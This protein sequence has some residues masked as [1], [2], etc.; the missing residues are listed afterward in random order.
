MPVIKTVPF[1]QNGW[2]A[3]TVQVPFV[4]VLIHLSGALEYE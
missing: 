2:H 1:L 3:K 4:F